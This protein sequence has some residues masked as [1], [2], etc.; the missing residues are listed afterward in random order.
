MLHYLIVGNDHTTKFPGKIE[1]R[2]M[3]GRAG[4]RKAILHLFIRFIHSQSSN[5]NTPQ[6]RL[7]SSI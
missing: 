5:K 2:A 6:A 4:Y 3:T 7:E 1:S